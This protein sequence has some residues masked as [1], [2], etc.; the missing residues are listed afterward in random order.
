VGRVEDAIVEFFTARGEG[1]A[2]A[3]LF[4]SQARGTANAASDI[5]VAILFS[6]DRPSG[7]DSLALDI[8]DDLRAKLKKPT[9]LLVLNHAPVDVVHRVLQDGILLVN[10]NPSLRIR[11]EV[12]AR[13]EGL[14]GYSG[15]RAWNSA[16]CVAFLA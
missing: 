1:I 6:H 10:S 13:N 7:L 3:Y 12:K 4:G 5:E 9:Q 15:P 8:E 14:S 16:E 2:A 11:F